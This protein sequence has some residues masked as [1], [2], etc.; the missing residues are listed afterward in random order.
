MNQLYKF[1]SVL[2]LAGITLVS[3]AQ[4]RSS[5]SGTVRNPAGEAL[6]G[7][8]VTNKST[9]QAAATDANGRY[10]IAAAVT[11]VL[12]F[13]SVGYT[14]TEEVVGDRAVVDVELA[15]GNAAL[16]E[17]VVVGYGTQK[18]A[19][20]TGAVSTIS[21]EVIENRPVTNVSSSLA[22]LASGVT[23]QQSSGKPGEDGASIRIRGTGSFNDAGPLV[24]IDGI[25]GV[26]D[27]V[28]P[29]DIESMSVLKDASSASIYGAQAANGVILITTKKGRNASPQVTYTGIA[30][31]ANP[32]NYPQFVSDYVRHMELFNEGARNIGQ[33]QPYSQESIDAWTA[34][35]ANP[36]AVNEFGIPNYVA[37]PN[38]D[39]GDAIFESNVVQNHNVSVLGGGENV[40]YNVS[41]R[42]L[43]NPGVMANTGLKRYEGRV[44]VEAKMAKFLTLGTQTFVSNQHADRGNTA[45]AFN[46]LRQT[47]PGLYPIYDGRFGA[48]TSSDESPGLNNIMVHLRGT[49][50]RNETTRLNT[51]LY[52]NVDII[53][54]LRLESRVNYQSRLQEQ[55][56]YTVPTERWNF[57]TNEVIVQLPALSTLTTSQSTNKNYTLTY[58]NVLRY[59]T[60]IG[61]RH[62]I[63]A[64]V[65]HNEYYYN[66]YSFSASMMGLIDASIT[67]IG[68]G[69]EM[70]SI[71]GQEYDRSMRSFFGRVNYAFDDKYLFEA[72]IRRDGSS[73]FGTARKWGNFPSFSAG[74]RLSEEP[75]MEGLNPYV[76]NVKLRASW[77]KLGN[78]ATQDPNNP[79]ISNYAWQA[80]YGGVNYSF[81]GVQVVG[82][83][84]A[85]MANPYL[86]WESMTQT[87]IGLEFNLINNKLG[88]ETDYYSRYTEG[89]LTVPPIYLTSGTVTGPTMNTADMLNR[90]VEVG[91]RWNDKIGNVNYSLGGNFAYNHNVVKQFRGQLEEGWVTDA[92]GNPVYQSNLSSVSTGSTQRVVEGYGY[93][94]YYLR[95]RYRGDATYFN[96]DGSVNINGGPGDGMIRTPEDLAWVNAM[97]EAGYSFSPVNNVGQAQLYYGDFIFA[98]LNGDGI[99]GNNF[100]QYFTGKRAEPKYTF[101]FNA[102]FSWKGI[103]FSMLWS[104]V[105]GMYYYWNAEGY[106]NSIVRN[107]NAVAQR[108]A[109]DHYYY[110][111]ADPSDPGNNINGRFPR[112][113]YNGDAINNTA[114]ETWLYN[115]SYIKLRNVQLGY[116]FPV[117]LT[118]KAGIRTAR[119]F[120][121][122]EN[123]F[124][125]TSYPGLDPEVGAAI[126]Y[127]SMRQFALG[128]NIGF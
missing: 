37:Y 75:F 38:T 105:A 28:N 43:D 106:D 123:L 56:S 26:M 127:P 5:I 74:W 72:N 80:L 54:G 46:F 117:S 122:G 57:A 40:N 111:P 44:N 71:S 14:T 81:N 103:D 17:V 100:D 116:T 3:W 99:Y 90:G 95:Q 65:G 55:T 60:N 8:S 115:S 29:N 84:P 36:N 59:N 110:N 19:N 16:D 61:G 91:L 82:L 21:S 119:V 27:A 6:A 32:S 7:I 63:G 31:I 34:A 85:K 41:A 76:Q 104:G 62:E 128:L 70:N 88:V 64:L 51:T 87:D 4:E 97:R 58:D 98:D 39:W 48:P 118:Q 30:S 77:G 20:L 1:L 89:I 15:E 101:G 18:R 45:N 94:E 53:K 102:A 25:I 68:S 67:N 121:T 93:N 49:D 126:D 120:F 108:I 52:G 23:V 92:A 69:T 79:A 109:D 124:I 83:R 73:R 22:G 107:G 11:D 114:N 66:Y 12:V 47:T 33:T 78:D 35:N 24:L 86:M 113:K 96:T 112:L 9:G 125:I 13:T 10:T 50:G 42:I 2:C